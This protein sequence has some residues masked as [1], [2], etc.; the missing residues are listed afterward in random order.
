MALSYIMRL[1]CRTAVD[2]RWHGKFR[3]EGKGRGIAGR[4]T[5]A[6]GFA[7]LLIVA[8]QSPGRNPLSN[9]ICSKCKRYQQ[10]DTNSYQ[11]NS[12][13]IMS[14]LLWNASS[15]WPMPSTGCFTDTASDL[16]CYRLR[17]SALPM[18]VAPR[19][20]FTNLVF[21]TLASHLRQ[22]PAG[23]RWRGN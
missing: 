7:R 13:Y 2:L 10:R 9:W 11:M 23:H 4:S 22:A 20:P 18:F 21:E 15:Q 17:P 19:L 14:A 6:Q 5:W 12:Q 16:V 8:L 1:S 3:L